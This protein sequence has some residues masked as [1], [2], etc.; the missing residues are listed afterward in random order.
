MKI[1]LRQVEEACKELYIRAV[2]ILPPDINEGFARLDK[3]E[4]DAPESVPALY[5]TSIRN[6]PTPL[7]YRHPYLQ[8]VIGAASKSTERSKRRSPPVAQGDQGAALLVFRAS[9]TLGTSTSC[10]SLCR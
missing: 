10:G 2:K 5:R 7:A 8:L 3:T 4:T 1:D 6:T 9:G